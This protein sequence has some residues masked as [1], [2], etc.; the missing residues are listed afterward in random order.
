MT[1]APEGRATETPEGKHDAMAR[2]VLE[3]VSKIRS[4]GAE[5]LSDVSF[6]A[7]H[8]SFCVLTGPTG[9][10]KTTVLRLLASLETPTSGT[11][12]IGD[13]VSQSWRLGRQEVAELVDPRA[14]DGARN[15]YDNMRRGLRK[16]GLKRAE[17]EAATL[18]AADEMELGWLLARRPRSISLGEASRAAL[19]RAFAHQPRVLLFDEPF[20]GL[21]AARKISLRRALRRLQ[22]DKGATAVFAIQD[23]TD[24]LALADVLVVMEQ[25]RV[26]GAGDPQ[27]LYDRPASAALGRLLG[28]PGM[29]LLPVRANQTGLSLEDGTHLG[30]A[31]VMTTAVFALI[32]VRA[33][34]LFPMVD[35]AP[36]AAAVLPL[37]VED[38]ERAGPETLVHGR[39]G[40]FPV[41]A[42]IAGPVEIPASGPL[43][44]GAVRDALHMFDAESGARM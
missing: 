14:L 1:I 20:Q 31:S 39:V 11:I 35:G 27:A 30:G 5:V 32:G 23:Q 41:S 38:V 13:A 19:G 12:E 10:G 3:H 36:P 8:C 42:R 34:A 18:A 37:V 26:M 7:P 21:D 4:G 22:R 40:L 43:R 16:R 2:I 44:L 15:L 24:A 17:A 25:G 28:A 29:N 33:E 6:E 9:A